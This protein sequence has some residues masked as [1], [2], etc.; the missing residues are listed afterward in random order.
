[1]I[2]LPHAVTEN[3]RDR[4]KMV[5]GIRERLVAAGS[6]G[7]GQTVKAIDAIAKELG[8]ITSVNAES[9]ADVMIAYRDAEGYNEMIEF[10]EAMPESL[11]EHNQVMREQLALA[12]NRRNA[13]GDRERAIDI[14]TAIVKERGDNPETCGILGRIYKDRYEEAK[15]EFA[16]DGF[17]QASIDWYSRGF[18]A[19]PRDFYPGINLLTMLAAKG[20]LKGAA[21]VEE[22]MRRTAAVLSFAL[23]RQDAIRSRDYWTVA[24]LLEA[25]VHDNDWPTA[26]SA[27]G[28]LLTTEPTPQQLRT[29]RKNLGI[30]AKAKLPYVDAE[31]LDRLI[32]AFDSRLPPEPPKPPP[33]SQQPP[34]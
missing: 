7:P 2:E 3:F 28:V 29:T 11:R 12:L 32:A 26:N 18:T 27:M 10:I 33:A 25:S 19:D 16:I 4:A 34:G 24:T 31:R 15:D 5:N 21:T 23:A 6:L 30:I 22:Q 13:T 14:L 9:A 1:M 8:P 17:L 20:A